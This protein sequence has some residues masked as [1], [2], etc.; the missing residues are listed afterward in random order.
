[1]RRRFQEGLGKCVSIQ[2]ELFHDIC[3]PR[4][5]RDPLEPHI[6]NFSAGIGNDLVFEEGQVKIDFSR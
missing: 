1:V 3:N 5:G 2:L 4:N 6:K